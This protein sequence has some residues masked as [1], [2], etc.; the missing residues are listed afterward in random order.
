MTTAQ[1]PTVKLI[2]GAE[3]PV[4]GLG[5]WPLRGAECA[6]AV[7]TAIES[8]Y[9]LVDTAENYRNEDGVG[10]GIRDSGVDRSEVFITTKFNKEWHSIEGVREAFEASRARL[11]VEYIDLMLI[12]WPNPD[13]DRYVDA[14]LGLERMLEHGHVRAIGVSNFKPAHLQRVLDETGIVV[15]VNQIQLSPYT[16]RDASRA[17]D[18]EHGIVTESW[19]PIGGSSDDLR[20]D[21]VLAEIAGR[22]GK[23][24]TQT[25]LRWHIQLGL[26]TVPKSGNPGRIAE[27]IDIFDFA[28]SDEEM[29]TISGLDRGESSVTDSDTFGH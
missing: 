25:V 26:V 18:T 19:S 13:L 15:D 4:L 12:H 5:T 16:T 3:M 17:F 8:G 22:H 28:L 29:A 6:A 10:Q 11:G 23:S 24:V 1:T 7:R 14:V 27:N 2:N 20:S 21:P 9:R